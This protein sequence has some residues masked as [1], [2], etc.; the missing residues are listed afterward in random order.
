[1]LFTI[2]CSHFQKYTGVPNSSSDPNS[3][4]LPYMLIYIIH[5]VHFISDQDY[6]DTSNL[7]MLVS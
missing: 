5:T 3:S 2:R 4:P 1:M 6:C 7:M